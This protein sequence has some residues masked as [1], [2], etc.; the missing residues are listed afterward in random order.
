MVSVVETL[1]KKLEFRQYRVRYHGEMCRIEVRP[2]DLPRLVTEPIRQQV[3]SCCQDAG[4]K[5][6][7]LDL[8]G[9]R[10]GS[11]NEVLDS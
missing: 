2:E 1:L 11:L 4:F 6:V 8:Q 10:T 3:L 5:Y 7:T 9:Y